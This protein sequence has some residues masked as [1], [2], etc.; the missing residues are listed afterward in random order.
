MTDNTPAPSSTGYHDGE[1]AVQQRAGVRAEARRLVRMLD[2]AELTPGAAHFLAQQ[3][4]AVI[5]GRDEH[6]RLWTSPLTGPSG[7]LQVLDAGTLRIRAAPG[8]GD[9]LHGLPAGQPL[10]LVAIELAKRRRFRINGRLVGADPAVLTV[11]VDQAYGNCPQYIQQ[12][13]LQ[14]GPAPRGTLSHHRPPGVENA[15]TAGALDRIR[16]ADTFFLGTTHETRGNDASH[17]GGPA[18]FVR[19]E[20]H[21][22]RWPDYPGNN[23]FNSLGNLAV[24]PTASLLFPDFDAGHSLHLTGRA[25]LELIDVGASGDDGFTGRVVRFTTDLVSTGPPLAL[26]AGHVVPYPRNPPLRD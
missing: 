16:R 24:D 26:R 14:P 3:T 17:R 22:L 18:G 7:F 20:D 21:T 23:M 5:T 1:L 9:P 6:G 19:V 11:E 8:V 15:L 2:P 13:V 4:L 10:G 25:A 12:R